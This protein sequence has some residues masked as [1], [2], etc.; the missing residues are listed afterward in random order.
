MSQI[1]NEGIHEKDKSPSDD[2]KFLGVK[3]NTETDDFNVK[4]NLPPKTSL[5]KRDVVSII[6]SVY[7][8]ISVTAPLFIKLKSLM[9]E[10][11]DTG[12]KRN[13]YV[14]PVM[15][16]RWNSICKGSMVRISAFP[17]QFSRMCEIFTL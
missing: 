8:P 7:D 17:G 10:I 16:N 6:N 13:D 15:T 1:V 4:V 11:Y 3:Y 12:I 14:N 9:R 5:T 2:S